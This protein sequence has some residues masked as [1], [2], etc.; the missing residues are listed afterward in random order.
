MCVHLVLRS[1]GLCGRWLVQNL[2]A[3]LRFPRVSVSARH[4]I[5]SKMLMYCLRGE[6]YNRICC[7]RSRIGCCLRA[8]ARLKRLLLLRLM[9]PRGRPRVLRHLARY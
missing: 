7:V 5:I 9:L 6:I 4:T 1:F 3:Q 2:F 8:C